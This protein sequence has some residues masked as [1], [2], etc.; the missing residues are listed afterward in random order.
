VDESLTMLGVSFGK[1]HS[2]ILHAHKNIQEKMSQDENLRRY[3]SMVRRN[4][5]D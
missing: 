5:M 4:L 3:I 1:T 2:T